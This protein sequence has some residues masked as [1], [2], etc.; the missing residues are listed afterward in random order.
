MV[1]LAYL[2]FHA[3]RER[4]R[5]GRGIV[6]TGA[7]MN[8]VGFRLILYQFRRD[9]IPGSTGSIGRLDAGQL[10]RRAPLR[11]FARHECADL[12]RRFQTDHVAQ[13]LADDG[14]DV[15]RADQIIDGA[16][17]ALEIATT[18]HWFRELTF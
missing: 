13:F 17:E 9:K 4:R 15:G 16:V 10:D 7:S 6:D 12:L 14:A 1:S 3:A 2:E 8:R 11:E 18:V 5:I